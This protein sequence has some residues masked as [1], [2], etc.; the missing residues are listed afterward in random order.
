MSK[1]KAIYDNYRAERANELQDFADLLKK[2]TALI[3]DLKPLNDAISECQSSKPNGKVDRWGYK[4]KNLTFKKVE[5][6]KN[7][8]PRTVEEVDVQLTVDMAAPCLNEE[9]SNDCMTHLA[10]NIIVTDS[11]KKCVQS[12]H[13]DRHI[14]SITQAAHPVYHFQNGGRHIW[15]NDDAF[16]GSMLVLES[17]RIG[18]FPMDGILAIDFVLSNYFGAEWKKIGATPAY[19]KIIA[20]MQKRFWKPYINSLYSVWDGPTGVYSDWD[21][22]HIC[23][24]IIKAEKFLPTTTKSLGKQKK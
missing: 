22:I 5:D 13:F 14:E 10:I 21:P 8:R 24:Q 19:K 7:L 16:F 3:Y 4:I 1:K 11:K 23:P 15:D 2:S 9:C 18:H 17:P 20:K 12:W 6:L